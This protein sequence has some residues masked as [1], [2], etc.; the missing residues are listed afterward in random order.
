M[1]YLRRSA[2]FFALLGITLIGLAFLLLISPTAAYAQEATPD[3]T[4]LNLPVENGRYF[5]TSGLCEVVNK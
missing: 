4:L 3:P 5:D 2:S 1:P